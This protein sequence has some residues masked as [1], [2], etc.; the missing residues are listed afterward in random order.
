MKTLVWDVDD[1]LNDLMRTWFE[2]AWL[3]AHPDCSIRYEQLQANPPDAFLGVDRHQYLASMDL[4]RLSPEGM[5]LHPDD[6]L[7]TWFSAHGSRFR[8]MALTARP[9]ESAPAVAAWVMQYF[10]SWIRVFGV[11]PSRAPLSA[12]VYDNTKGE[13]L[14]WLGKGDVLIDDSP[15]NLAQAAALGLQT[16]AWP[17]PW[18]RA[19]TSKAEILNQLLELA[20]EK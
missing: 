19:S 12:P 20:E 1:V 16:F 13:Y 15:E 8:H 6:E 9:L 14:R 17:Q 2:K 10:G 7:L 3:P 18:N 5:E 11:V 4:F